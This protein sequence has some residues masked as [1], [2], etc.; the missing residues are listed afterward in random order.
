V[1]PLPAPVVPLGFLPREATTAVPRAAPLVPP[2]TPRTA[3]TVPP[4]VTD[5]L[6]PRT[7]LASPVAYIQRPRQP[8]LVS[9][10]TLPPLPR[11][12]VGGQGMVVLVTSPENPHRMITWGKTGF[13]VVP[14]CLVLTTVTSSPT[15]SPIPSSTCAALA[16]PH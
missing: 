9:T 15:P 16:N 6:P 4:A 1:A 2:A 8:T 14:D 11:P 5:S 12:F 3:P 13:R 10:T 7:W